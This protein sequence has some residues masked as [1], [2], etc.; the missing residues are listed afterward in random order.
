MKK[1]SKQQ[2]VSGVQQEERYEDR[3]DKSSLGHGGESLVSMDNPDDSQL[4][5]D[6]VEK[7]NPRL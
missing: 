2:A 6:R 3:K 5:A 4:G 7:R 1:T